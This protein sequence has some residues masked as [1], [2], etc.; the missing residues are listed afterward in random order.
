VQPSS[1]AAA[2]SDRMTERRETLKY[3]ERIM[4][5]LFALFLIGAPLIYLI[6]DAMISSPSTSYRPGT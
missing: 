4:S 2:P 6:A 5:L 3:E 1:P